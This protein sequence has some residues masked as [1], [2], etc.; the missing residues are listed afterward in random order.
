MKIYNKSSLDG[1]VEIKTNTIDLILTSPPYWDL[2]DYGHENQLGLGLTYKTY[3][4]FL[5]SNLLA[6]ARVLKADGFC[7]FNVADIRKNL[8]GDKNS[9]SQIYSIQAYLIREFEE[10]GLELFSHII[11]RKRSVKK[12]KK[13]KILYG[14][15]D[16]EYIYTPYVYNDLSF[17]HILVFRKPGDRRVLPKLKDREDKYKKDEF[18]E[19]YDPIWVFDESTKGKEHP[20]RFPNKLAE[21]IIKMYSLKGDTILDPFAGSGTSLDEADKLSR[22]AIG[23]EVNLE[24]LK[25][26]ISK[27]N[28]IKV[29]T[30]KYTNEVNNEL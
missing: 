11:W 22:K 4:R 19:N 8:N 26:L 7:V 13:G 18:Q 20:A 21:T 15:V 1:M 16:G 27:Y 3:L 10:L 14:S 23:Y 30:S 9:R 25:E 2:K 5:N 6:C 12:G 24:H 28:I 17:E 29:E